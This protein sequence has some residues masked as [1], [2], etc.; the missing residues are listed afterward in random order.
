MTDV[1]PSNLTTILD[2]LETE[3]DEAR[4]DVARLKAEV[5]RLKAELADCAN[6]LRHKDKS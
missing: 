5:A 6:D 4:A 1:H 2:V 3:R